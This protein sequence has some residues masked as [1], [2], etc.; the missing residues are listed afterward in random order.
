MRVRASVFIATQVRLDFTSSPLDRSANA[1]IGCHF[2]H[3]T[4]T[5]I[6]SFSFGPSLALASYYDLG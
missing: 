5:R 1:N 3:I 6:H 2:Q 4:F